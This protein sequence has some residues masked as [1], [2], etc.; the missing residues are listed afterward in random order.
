M[1]LRHTLLPLALAFSTLLSF[2]AAAAGDYPSRSV[3]VVV[4]YPAGGVIDIATR[5]VTERLTQR[6]GQA[7][8]VEN[9]PGA[10]GNIGAEQ[11]R[12]ARADGHTL[13]IGSTFLVI[14]PLIDANT[15]FRH[16]DFTPI[17]SLGIPPNILVVP[18]Q[19][20]LRSVSDLVA[21]AKQRPGAL[22]TPQ[23]G[24]GSSNQ[25]GVGQFLASA[26]IDVL[27][28]GYQGQPPFIADLVNGELDFAFLT[29][30]L[31]LPQI[32]AGKLR[33][34]AII[35]DQRLPALPEV[36]TIVEEGHPDAAVL[37][38]IGVFGPKDLPPSVRDTLATQVRDIL[39]DPPVRQRFEDFNAQLPTDP[40]ALAQLV[41]TE[42]VRWTTVLAKPV[43]AVTSP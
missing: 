11:V 24:I 27:Q 13:L 41:E 2:P 42:N 33:P 23:P 25:L 28:V 15:Q 36:P 10:N 18:Q 26:D 9:K 21:L 5:Q 37:P 38:W 3:R 43:A 40:L 12:Q 22:N 17:A 32:K 39:A 35:S 30:A 14:S 6:L 19:S 1:S 29:A 4:P 8:V 34:L 16:T 7:F 20:T 31:A